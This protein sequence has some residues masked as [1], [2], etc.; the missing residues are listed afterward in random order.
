MIFLSAKRL[1]WLIFW[2]F[3]E[4]NYNKIYEGYVSGPLQM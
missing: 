3:S 1:K 4:W 2:L